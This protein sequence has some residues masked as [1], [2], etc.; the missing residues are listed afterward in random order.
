[1]VAR[2]SQLVRRD[3]K[4][5]VVA[6]GDP[7]SLSHKSPPPSADLFV[8][9]ARLRE[10]AGNTDEAVE[11]Y[12]KALGVTPDHRDALLG[13]ARLE[14]RRGR[15]DAA[16]GLYRR[17]IERHPKDP[18]PHNDLGLCY[19]RKG[20]FTQ[21][22]EALEQAVRL[23]PEGKRYRNNLASVLVELDRSDEALAELTAAHGPAIAHYNLGVLLEQRGHSEPA[24][25][26][27]AEALRYDPRMKAARDRLARLRASGP[28]ANRVSALAGVPATTVRPVPRPRVQPP[29]TVGPMASRSSAIG[30]RPRTPVWNTP[31]S[32]QPPVASHARRPNSPGT[33]PTPPGTSIPQP[34]RATSVP[35]AATP[36]LEMPSQLPALQPP[37][38]AVVPPTPDQINRYPISATP[39]PLP[40]YPLAYPH[41]R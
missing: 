39:D 38:Q 21:A 18:T 33:N 30:Q 23:A 40:A 1:M 26:Q 24:S 6:T 9:V 17:A 11:Y 41:N 13:L 36:S 37:G 7:I 34:S 31:S 3:K 35:A 19:A 10:R 27:F 22:A 15:F 14:D 5:R 16:I 20:Q 32:R 4:A 28:Q 29:V 25:R 12:Q 8:S 2:G